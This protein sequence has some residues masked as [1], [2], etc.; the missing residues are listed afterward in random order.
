MPG[1]R[2]REMRL[3]RGL[4]LEQLAEII[5]ISASALSQIERGVTKNV[6]PENF[7]RFCAFFGADP[8]Y[9]VFGKPRNELRD[10]LRPRLRPV[11]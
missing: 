9:V 10:L 2:M 3:S 4:S 11:E 5:G 8:Y 1:D 7:L 6:R